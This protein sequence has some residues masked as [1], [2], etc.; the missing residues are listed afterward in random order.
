MYRIVESLYL[1]PETNI[2]LYVNYT[3]I[4]IKFFKNYTHTHTRAH[5]HTHTHTA[6]SSTRLPLLRMPVAGVLLKLP[7]LLSD[8]ATSLE[9]P[10]MFSRLLVC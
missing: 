7:A 9:L 3:G 4:K 5:T 2:I 8:W 10:I 6:R 1:I